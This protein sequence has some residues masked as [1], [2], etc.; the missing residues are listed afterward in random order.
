MEHISGHM[1]ENVIRNSH[2]GF[3]K[4][5]LIACYDETT[6]SVDGERA[7]DV[8]CVSFM[9]KG[10]AVIMVGTQRGWRKGLTGTLRNSVGTTAK[11]C[12]WE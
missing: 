7:V 4:S 9:L 12:A 8:F 1:K 10:R 3:T 11:S 6:V 2:H 5:D